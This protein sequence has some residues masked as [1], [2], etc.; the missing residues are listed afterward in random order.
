MDKYACY[1]LLER[2]LIFSTRVVADI[3][4]L[5]TF[6]KKICCPYANN[7]LKINQRRRRN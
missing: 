7:D 6:A 1:N 4:G 2:Y 3:M 5:A